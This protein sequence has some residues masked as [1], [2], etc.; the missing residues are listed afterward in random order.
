FRS[1]NAAAQDTL[2]WTK[3]ELSGTSI[4]AISPESWQVIQPVMLDGGAAVRDVRIRWRHTNGRHIPT[5]FWSASIKGDWGASG[6]VLGII[7]DLTQSVRVEESLRQAQKMEAIGRLA[8]GIAHDFNNLLT[9]IGG[10]A[11]LCLPEV[12]G[13]STGHLSS[14]LGQIIAAAERA[15]SLTRQLLAFSRRQVLQPKIVDCKVLLSNLATM[16][17][18]I[19]G[20]DIELVL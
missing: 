7:V 2:G 17:R 4:A 8:G 12:D 18:R 14:Y 6:T 11:Q 3:E 20:E 19:M 13:G 16:L 15:A 5:A 9:V 1:W 10:Y